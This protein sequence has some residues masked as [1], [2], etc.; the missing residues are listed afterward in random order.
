MPNASSDTAV[1]TTEF[2][3]ERALQPL[4]EI[5]K[6][7][8]YITS[9][10]HAEVREYLL[11]EL[12]SLGLHPEVQEG[13][14]V[15]TGWGNSAAIDKPKNILAKINKKETITFFVTKTGK[16]LRGSSH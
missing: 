12:R 7:P 2:S 6:N 15:N 4:K 1:P 11:E 16:V 9:A 5:S 10:A 3:T 13:Y 14:I 8:H